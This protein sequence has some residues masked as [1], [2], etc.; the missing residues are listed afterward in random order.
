MIIPKQSNAS[1]KILS[2]ASVVKILIGIA[3]AI[4][5]ASSLA[6][7]SSAVETIDAGYLMGKQL[8][9]SRCV[10][11]HGGAVLKAP[12]MEA[13][14]LYPPERII[15]S[16]TS[17]VMSTTG[18]SLSA[19]EMQQVAYYVTGKMTSQKTADL[20][21]AFCVAD[22]PLK[23]SS[24]ASAQW[25]GWG[26]ELN[27][28]RFQANETRLNKQTVRDL[29][30]K[31]AFAFPD[32]SRVRSQPTVTD[33]MTYIGSQDGTLYALDTETGCIRWTFQ[34]E[35]E[36]RGAIKLQSDAGNLAAGEARLLFGDYKANA[37]ALNAE[38]GALLW[39]TK[40]HSHPLA[41][42]TG[43]VTADNKRVYVPLSSSEVVPAAQSAYACCTFRGAL[44]ALNLEDGSIAWRTYTTDKPERL[45]KN[46]VGVDR[47]GPSGAPIWSSPTLDI[48]RNLIYATTGQNYS[49]PATGTSDAVIAM[50]TATGE[51]K[52]VSQVTANDA[53]NGACGFTATNC[54]EEDGPDYDIGASA[55]LVTSKSN[56]DLL[57]VGQKSGLT[58]AMDPDQQGK[59]LWRQRVGS[60][61][62]MGGVHWG[63]SSDGER[64]YVGV[65]DL[66][67]KNRYNQGDPYPGVH[68][69]DPDTGEF[70]WRNVLPYLCPKGI[71]FACFQGISAAVSSS[72]GLVF[73]GGMD[74]RLRAFDA[75]SGDILWTYNTFTE[76]TTVNGVKGQGGSIEADGPV[77]ANGQLFVT[78]GYDKWAE[79]PGNVLLVFSLP[80]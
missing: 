39:K 70:L 15:Q 8:Y 65:S 1:S 24:P 36:V 35:N 20:S 9:Q 29:E 79:M 17:G 43:S 69:L 73:A 59:I 28:Q 75:S 61:G 49:S 57:L 68:A 37:Y 56:R 53:W 33:S 77:I 16:L 41:S 19:S 67:T 42:V 23:T 12:Q 13:L 7:E 25:T 4:L 6:E 66:P 2:N 62:T 50:D 34:A 31:W 51:V 32:A 76:F 22:I 45:G 47:F 55:I 52:W 10:S 3:V 27:S 74:G 44:V 14:K 21:D 38:T 72:P 18:L 46:A 30:L 58:Y 60:G 63:M 40:V 64:L 26:G 48:K 54:P 11:C 71:K 5:C 80:N 78:S